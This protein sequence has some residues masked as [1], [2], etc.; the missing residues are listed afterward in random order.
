MVLTT[1]SAQVLQQSFVEAASKP[2]IRSDGSDLPSF[3]DQS[4]ALNSFTATNLFVMVYDDAGYTIDQSPNLKRQPDFAQLLDIDRDTVYSSLEGNTQN[5]TLDVGV[6]RLRVLMVPLIYINNVTDAQQVAGV[7]QLVRPINETERALQIFLYAL[8]FGGVIV[9]IV[10]AQG[11]A[12]LSRAVFQPINQIVNTA[13]SIVS[14]T[15]LQ[16]RVPVPKTQNEFQSLINT[17]NELLDRIQELFQVQQKFLADVSHELR[18]PLAAMQGNIDVLKRGAVHDKAMLN[19]SLDDMQRETERL[20]RL[21]NDLLMLANNKSATSMRFEIVDMT[22]LLLEVVR[23]LKPIATRQEIELKLDV[24]QVLMVHGDRDRLKQA[25][26]NIC[27]NALQHTPPQ[28]IVTVGM[29][30]SGEQARIYVRDTGQ[31]I[32][33]QDIPNVFNRFFRADQSRTRT[34]N[35]TGSGAGL[36]LAIV[37]YI[38]EAHGGTVQVESTLQV[39]T[40]FTIVL[41]CLPEEPFDDE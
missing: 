34:Q 24:Q 32:A 18:T 28:G 19:E 36:G 29:R 38:V 4:A 10:V 6:V 39:G 20:I 27:M 2:R 12:W 23:E 15:D 3:L 30:R 40:T 22:T 31:G 37:K 25:V 9:L 8:A 33:P 21:V 35:V 14:A 41:S 13:Q 26:L 16:L 7:I 11:G 17:I 1:N 5:F